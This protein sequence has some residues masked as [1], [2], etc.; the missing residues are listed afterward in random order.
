MIRFNELLAPANLLSLSRIPLAILIIFFYQNWVI[1]LVLFGLALLS[2]FLDG[3][4]ARKKG[5]TV[6]GLFLDPLCDKIFA[7]IL[8]VFLVLVSYITVLQLFVLLLRDIF[9]VLIMVALVL[10]PKR[11][12]LKD[13]LKARWSGK[14]TTVVQF[15]A[16]MWV[17]LGI[18]YFT[19]AVYAVGLV[20]VVAI[21]D[22]C[23]L[24]KK[25]SSG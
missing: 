4:V 21:V 24:M 2:D 9:V 17:F 10:Y 16:V 7:V 14:V 15:I 23:I 19:Y 20:S 18:D 22:Y 13:R 8:L 1:L 11:H 25:W 6:L 5:P 3:Y 12:V